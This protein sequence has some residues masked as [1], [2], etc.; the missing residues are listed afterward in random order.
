MK[1]RCA[2]VKPSNTLYV[3]YHDTE[4][5]VP[6]HDDQKLFE[7]IVLEGAQAGLTW[8]TILNRRENYRKA[9]KNFDPVKVAKFTVSDVEKLMQNSGIIRNRLKIQSTITNAQNFLKI[10]K[11]FN[12]FSD[13]MWSFVHGKPIQNKWKE[14]NQIPVADAIAQAL[15]KDMKKRGFKFFGP[16]ICYAHMQ[17]VG[18]VNDHVTHCFRYKEVQ[19]KHFYSY[20]IMKSDKYLI[21]NRLIS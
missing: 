8:E 12:K 16:T 19:Q 9:F 1:N 14:S 6:V 21:S 5:A 10:Q 15:S 18:M 13:Y 20:N 3:T 7:F 11:E 2:W 17:A 4:W